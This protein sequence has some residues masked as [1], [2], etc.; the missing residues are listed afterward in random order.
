MPT[1]FPNPPGTF[2]QTTSVRCS[3]THHS[4]PCGSISGRHLRWKSFSFIPSTDRHK[5]SLIKNFNPLFSLAQFFFSRGCFPFRF[6]QSLPVPYASFLYQ[7]LSGGSLSCRVLSWWLFSLLR[8]LNFLVTFQLE[9][10]AR[11]EWGVVDYEFTDGGWLGGLLFR[12]PFIFLLEWKMSALVP[13]SWFK[14][15]GGRCGKRLRKNL[16][17]K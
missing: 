2:Q 1:A 7:R 14:G 15:G 17:L 6:R 4:P 11:M 12:F 13:V 10:A 8:N 5:I 3:W 16:A 9:W